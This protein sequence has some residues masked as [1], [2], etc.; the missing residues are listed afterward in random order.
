MTSRYNKSN[1]SSERSD[2]S[3]R[4]ERSRDESPSSTQVSTEQT[5]A[6]KTSNK[7]THSS[8]REPNGCI[9]TFFNQHT[10]YTDQQ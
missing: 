6:Q 1:I 5:Y 7:G 8:K 9:N 10:E 2:Q 3:A 4:R